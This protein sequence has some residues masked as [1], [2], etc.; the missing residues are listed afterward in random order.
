MS[1]QRIRIVI[2]DDHP[3]F[4]Q[5]LKQVIVDDPRFELVAEAEDGVTAIESIRSQ[6]PDLAVLD[7]NLPDISGLDVANQLR[8]SGSTTR[9]VIL[10]MLKD[11]PAFNRAM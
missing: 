5:G 2:V 1:T 11:E 8:E 10:T 3:L 9:F 4:R 6:E 7:I